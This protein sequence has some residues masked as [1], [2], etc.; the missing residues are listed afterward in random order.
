MAGVDVGADGEGIDLVEGQVW[1][2]DTR[3]GE[4][5]STLLINRIDDDPELGVVFHLGL[6]GLRVRNDR[7]PGGVATVMSHCPVSLSTL[8]RSLRDLVGEEEPDP[9]YLAG[10]RQWRE[11][12]DGGE[13]GVWD[14]TIAEIVDVMEQ[15]INA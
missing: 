1:T 12:A 2:Y 10:Y 9:G 6:R 13:G 15:V 14:L 8:Q 11:A 5:G 3:D 4:E 7:A